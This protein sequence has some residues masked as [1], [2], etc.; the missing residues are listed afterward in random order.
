MPSYS[1]E[2]RLMTVSTS[3][4]GDALLI[5]ELHGVEAISSLFQFRLNLLAE[6]VTV[7]PFD[8]LLGQ[9]ITVSLELPDAKDTRYFSGIA[10]R[11]VRG[12]RGQEFTQY[13]I[14]VVPE[15]WLLT[16]KFQSRIF[17][18]MSVPDILRKVLDGLSV[19]YKLEGTFE[20]RVYCVQYR[21]TD[22]N[23]ASRLMEEEGIFYFFTHSADGHTMV[24]TNTLGSHPDVPSAAQI[25]YEE[26]EGQYRD[27][28]RIQSF[29][30]AQEIRSG[31]ITFFD[32][33]FELPHKHL[34]V[35]E[36]VLDGTIMVGE[37][38]H[39]LKVGPT[40]QLEI[41][42][43]PGGYAKRFDG[44][45]SKIFSD[46]ARTAKI[47][48]Q[49]EECNAVVM[50][51]EGNCRQFTSGHKF[52]LK[53]HFSDDGQY[54][55]VS[56]S[57]SCRQNLEFRSYGSQE[58]EMID[59]SNQFTCIPHSIPF[60]PPRIAARPVVHGTQTAVVTG[61]SGEEIYTD[62]YGRIKVQFH[63]DRSGNGNEDSSCWVRVATP[64]AGK[65]WGMFT[66]PR[67]GQEVVVD[68]LEGDPDRPLVVGSVY[69]TDQTQAYELPA[70]Q[71]KSY[72]KSF[73]SKGGKGFNEIRLEDSKGKEQIFIHA[74]H[75]KD[76]RIK[77][78]RYE[79]IGSNQHLIVGADQ[80]E[81][82]KGDKH[83]HVKGDQNE[84]VVGSLS[85]TLGMDHQEKVGKNY[86]LDAGMAIHLKAGMTLVIEAGVQLSLKVGGNFIDINPAGV[87]IQGTMVMINSGGSAGSG[88]G[89]SPETPK[90]PI[91]ADKAEPGEI[92]QVRPEP[93]KPAKPLNLQY[94]AL[95]LA[96]RQAADNG[97]PFCGP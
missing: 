21:E 79:M 22:F 88:A 51:G 86:A 68:F 94:G 24:V 3:I 61:P 41:Y 45:P 87:F 95:A 71:T 8:K 57:H 85:Q 46:G 15:F 33:T 30:K 82:V 66:L 74:E 32:H 28:D 38:Q 81:L 44:S 25:I 47:R 80:M 75:N 63:W 43:Y 54:V 17:Q 26:I 4:G 9:K 14:E 13:Q 93:P 97:T 55:L 40:D 50:E 67:I 89:A 64:W 58:D 91:E 2:G 16:K 11:V 92:S 19:D 5:Q 7:I 69:N 37:V 18:K 96:F 10:S 23:F 84:K 73:S 35:Q 90:E 78:D 1:Q 42:D 49:S 31:Q 53:R 6:N 34:D 12:S 39:K 72:F 27:E 70:Q 77:N 52:E 65:G 56:V 59:Y 76:V 83:L 20:P 62:Q 36:M 48:M 29:N 60:R